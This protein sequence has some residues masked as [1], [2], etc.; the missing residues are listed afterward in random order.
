MTKIKN[1]DNVVPLKTKNE[2]DNSWFEKKEDFYEK[3]SENPFSAKR[4]KDI[5]DLMNVLEESIISLR[6][7]L[8]GDDLD[9]IEPEIDLTSLKKRDQ[10]SI[11]NLLDDYN[12]YT[13]V[14]LSKF[15]E[16]MGMTPDS[17]M[18]LGLWPMELD[19]ILMG[20]IENNQTAEDVGDLVVSV[21]ERI[22][23]WKKPILFKKPTDVLGLVSQFVADEEAEGTKV[24]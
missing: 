20:T 22:N 11:L 17:E 7:S 18:Q 9:G 3:C 15:E 5:S 10:I 2:P 23:R 24:F 6:Y 16:I 4:S 8:M 12:R 21:Q 14:V 1:K 19:T 13:M